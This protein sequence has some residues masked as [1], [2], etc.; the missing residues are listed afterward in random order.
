MNENMVNKAVRRLCLTAAVSTLL[1]RNACAGDMDVA[2]EALRDGLYTVA[3]TYADR[4]LSRRGADAEQALLALLEALE[5]QRR[6]DEM[7]RRLEVEADLARG[8]RLREA[9]EYWRSVALLNTGRPR[10][11]AEAAEAAKGAATVYADALRMTA[12]RA[13]Q[14]D[15]DME[16]ALSLYAEVDRTSTNAVVRAA[17]ALDWALA[18]ERVGM[19]EKALDTLKMQ[20]ELGVSNDK[21]GEGLLL[22]ARLLLR[23]GKTEEAAMNFNRLAMDERASEAAR[24][25]AMVEMSVHELSGGRTNEAV[26]YARS[27]FG[28]AS[29]PETRRLAGFRLGDLLLSG[30]AT[31]DE[32]AAV[33]KALV[34]EFPDH[35]M[36][37]RA[38]INLAD[39]LLR[40]GLHERAAKE[41]RIYIETYPASS[42]DERA[43]QGRGWALLRLERF[44]EAVSAFMRAADTTTNRSVKAECLYK[45]AD[46]L[47]ADQRYSEAAK[48]YGEL[49][50]N[51]PESVYAGRAL[52]QSADS[53]ERAGMSDDAAARY[54]QVADGYPDSELAPRALLRLAG[55]Q[56]G[57]GD[58][59]GAIKTYT[60]LIGAFGQKDVQADAL[61]GRGKA[62]YRVYRFDSAMQDFATVAE[63]DARRRDEAR[64]MIALCLYGL[65]RDREARAAAVSFLMNFP[66]SPRLPDTVLWLGKYDYN[67]GQYGDARRFFMDYVTRWPDHL[68][69]DAALLWAARSAVGENDLTGAVETVTRLARSYPQSSRMPEALLVQADALIELARFDEA[70]LLLEQ[71][72]G[73]APDSDWSRMALVRKGDSLFAMGADNGV[74]YQEALDAY[75]RRLEQGNMSP[76]LTLQLHFKVGRCL[77]K[78][79]RAEEAINHYYAEVILRYQDERRRGVWYDESGTTLFVRAAFNL[80]EMYEVRRETEQA[81]RILQRVVQM[82]VP[83]EEEARARIGRLRGKKAGV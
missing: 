71:V 45:R 48:A 57:G 41:Y 44:S 30:T 20:G 79:K 68:W 15:G 21:T 54:R 83:G 6:F 17:N 31:I 29:L 13:R 64:F 26:A 42:L 36:S 14:A 50:Q 34:R 82:G 47:L 28:R 10:E 18:L 23:G 66:E 9:F 58:T 63:T 25:Q 60:V 53:F 37:M 22:R 59:E 40:Q 69:A 80:A 33:I 73:Q 5:G 24:V 11:A 61:M 76:S 46:A 52:F 7:L 1:A 3:E 27:A 77:E 65:G 75:R 32:A 78:L 67:R 8:A 2:K 4:V 55:L 70:A 72:I 49:W 38:Q 19:T 51:Y 62:C 16:R 35:P 39:A 43:L 12:A 74:R 56:A 81:V